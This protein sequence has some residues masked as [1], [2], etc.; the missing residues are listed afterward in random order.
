MPVDFENAARD[1]RNRL[2]REKFFCVRPR[3]LERWLWT[4]RIP[5]SAERVFW[6]HWQE[7]MQRGDWCSELPI[8]R[9]AHECHLDRSAERAWPGPSLTSVLR[10]RGHLGAFTTCGYHR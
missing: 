10:A 1:P 4:Q 6:L 7:G 8:R 2:V 3:P 5:S 9:V